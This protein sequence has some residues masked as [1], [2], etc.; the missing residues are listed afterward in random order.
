MQ[1]D[2]ADTEPAATVVAEIATAG[3]QAVAD[4]HDVSTEA[5]ARDLVE[6]ALARFGRVDVLINN[7]GIM[8]WAGMPEVDEETLARHLAVHLG[9]AFH[10]TRAAWPHLVDRGYG[11]ILLTTSAGV[12]GLAQNLAYATAKGAVIGLM[13]SLATAGAG[14]GIRVNCIAPAAFTRMAGPPGP[15]TD[16]M[17]P[18]RVAPM[19]A[20]LTHE[21]CPVTGEVYAAG[22]GRFA[23]IVLAATDGWVATTPEPTVEDVADHWAAIRDPSQWYAP[24]DLLEWSARFMRHLGADDDPAS[25]R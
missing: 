22:A 23:R 14:H 2:G 25:D 10:T 4:G 24:A 21:D 6:G 15:G 1:G 5:G 20:F 12:F 11:R 3:G 9:G 8:R 16:R 17:E 18:E 13:R 19:A 7:A